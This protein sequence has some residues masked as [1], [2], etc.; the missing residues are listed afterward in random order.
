MEIRN[1]LIWEGVN[2]YFLSN[3]ARYRFKVLKEF[4][5]YFDLLDPRQKAVFSL[6]F[7]G[8]IG[9]EF[10]RLYSLKRDIKNFSFHGTE[11]RRFYLL[12]RLWKETKNP[13][14]LKE[15][16]ELGYF[17]ADCFVETALLYSEYWD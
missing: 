14:F 11:E 13:L 8:E 16:S 2:K 3:E 6:V 5:W 17:W 10:F 1:G 15:M 9:E 7:S 4:N 12:K